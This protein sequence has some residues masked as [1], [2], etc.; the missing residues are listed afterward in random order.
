MTVARVYR[1]IYM[2]EIPEAI[3]AYLHLICSFSSYANDIA[4]AIR[5]SVRAPSE[6]P[7][8]ITK[9]NAKLYIWLVLFILFLFLA[10][11]TQSAQYL[12]TRSHKDSRKCSSMYIFVHSVQYIICV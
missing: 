6:K 5:E 4:L 12:K 9:R 11:T 7:Q 3:P 8:G 10:H 1:D 2:D